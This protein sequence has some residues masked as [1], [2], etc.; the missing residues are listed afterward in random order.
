VPVN[1]INRLSRRGCSIPLDSGAS[2]STNAD[3]AYSGREG[4][5]EQPGTVNASSGLS[6]SMLR[7]TPVSTCSPWLTGCLD[8]SPAS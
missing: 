7:T 8:E 6:N 3:R 4:D 2:G 5:E 1:G